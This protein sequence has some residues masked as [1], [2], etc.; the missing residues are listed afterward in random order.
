MP[1]WRDLASFD[2]TIRVD[3]PEQRLFQSVEYFADWIRQFA[4]Q[5]QE[6]DI[7]QLLSRCLRG[8]AYAWFSNYNQGLDLNKCLEELVIE[9]EKKIPTQAISKSLSLA[10][11]IQ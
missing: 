3:I 1:I 7:L 4:S 9:F 11:R 8:P 2:L 10:V 5:Y 6:V